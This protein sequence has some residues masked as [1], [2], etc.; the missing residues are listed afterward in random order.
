M[1]I[2]G[3]VVDAQADGFQ[4]SGPKAKSK[5]SIA[6]V[7]VT[8]GLGPEVGPPLWK[9]DRVGAYGGPTWVLVTGGSRYE[10]TNLIRIDCVDD[11]VG[12][13]DRGV[14]GTRPRVDAHR[15]RWGAG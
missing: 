10:Q 11:G 14:A 4:R 1:Q 3:S 6:K 7:G 5:L 13:V 8:V 9:R 15:L 2:T 12:L